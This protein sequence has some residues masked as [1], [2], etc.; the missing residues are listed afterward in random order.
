MEKIKL[1]KICHQIKYLAEK[2]PD[3]FIAIASCS[4]GVIFTMILA[5]LAKIYF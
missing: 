3:K 4:L 2:E 1:K 5:I